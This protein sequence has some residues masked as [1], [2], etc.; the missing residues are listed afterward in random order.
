MMNAY[1][2]TYL[3]KA[4]IALGRMLDYAIYDLKFELSTFWKQ[5]L[6]SDVCMQYEQG[7]PSILAGRSGVELALMVLDLDENTCQ[8]SYMEEKSDV[9]W[10]GWALAYYQWETCLSFFR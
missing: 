5:F 6:V 7:N 10:L 8:D 1:D 3:E 4:R 9:Y 2:R